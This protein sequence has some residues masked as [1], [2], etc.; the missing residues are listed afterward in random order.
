MLESMSS[1]LR[2]RSCSEVFLTGLEASEAAVDTI[3]GVALL[4]FRFC[5][6]RG[7]EDVDDS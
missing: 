6:I 1:A 5:A 3:L 4:T 7:V 2:F